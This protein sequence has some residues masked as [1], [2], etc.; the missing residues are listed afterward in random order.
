MCVCVFVYVCVYV[1]VYVYLYMYVCVYVCVCVCVD[2][3]HL[4]C[5]LNIVTDNNHMASDQVKQ[6]ITEDGKTCR[7]LKALR[8]ASVEFY[9]HC[10]RLLRVP[11]RICVT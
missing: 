8:K 9:W 1:Y 6:K 5:R 7:S 3:F 2:C 11:L 4:R 10:E